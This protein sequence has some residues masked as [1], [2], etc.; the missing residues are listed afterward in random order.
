MS[1]NRIFLIFRFFLKKKIH[2]KHLLLNLNV[3]KKQRS[4]HQ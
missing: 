1:I 3:N 2:K 4:I